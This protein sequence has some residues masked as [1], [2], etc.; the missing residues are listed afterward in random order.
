MLSASGQQTNAFGL[1]FSAAS[2]STPPFNP[3]LTDNI[4]FLNNVV[5]RQPMSSFGTGQKCL[6]VCMPS[7]TAPPDDL[8]ARYVGNVTWTFSDKDQGAP[9]GNTQVDTITFV[10]PA[11][12][13]YTLAEPQWIGSDGNLAGVDMSKL[14]SE[15]EE[16]E[17]SPSRSIAFQLSCSVTTDAEPVVTVSVV[18]GSVHWE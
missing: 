2:G 9:A 17:P 15:E 7:P 12:G 10:D 13:D 5:Q 1:Y 8:S 18:E 16:P 6:D 4:W 11:N 3:P 14:P